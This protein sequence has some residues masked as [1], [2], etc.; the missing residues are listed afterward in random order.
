VEPTP[1]SPI[2]VKQKSSDLKLFVQESDPVKLN[3][4]WQT[5]SPQEKR[6]AVMDHFM[7]HT[8][9]TRGLEESDYQTLLRIDR[10]V[11]K[12]LSND[13]KEDKDFHERY[14]DLSD[15]LPVILGGVWILIRSIEDK[16]KENV[17][18][19]LWQDCAIYGLI[20]ANQAVQLL[21]SSNTLLFRFS[22][23]HLC[24]A[25]TM[26]QYSK[27]N[28]TVKHEL[29]KKGYDEENENK[30]AAY[31]LVMANR[32]TKNVKGLLQTYSTREKTSWR[33]GLYQTWHKQNYGNF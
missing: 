31:K 11:N 33:D 15:S 22:L 12:K 21:H 19:N 4:L 6:D 10:A 20:D 14:G 8:R 5:F 2:L 18:A 29:L 17:V 1:S 26:K 32:Q 16:L 3:P 27:G 13:V 25:I 24:L 23:R 9:T 28:F 7:I 30:L